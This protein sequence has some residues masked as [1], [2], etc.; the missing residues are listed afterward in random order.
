[1]YDIHLRNNTVKL[2]K[3]WQPL[4]Q[5][6]PKLI[7][8]EPLYFGFY[9]LNISK[10]IPCI[11]P[12]GLLT[13]E[14]EWI[15][16]IRLYPENYEFFQSNSNEKNCCLKCFCWKI[17]QQNLRPNSRLYMVIYAIGSLK[18]YFILFVIGSWKP[19]IRGFV[20]LFGFP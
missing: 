12:V 19:W 14:S 7:F 20:I 2:E 11:W 5:I 9:V 15:S 18:V 13:Y 6:E 4:K 10:K 16:V 8:V 1:M 17:I 3:N